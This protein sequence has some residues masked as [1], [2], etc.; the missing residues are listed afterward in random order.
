LCE[1]GRVLSDAL[2][3]YRPAWSVVESCRR[4]LFRT[5]GKSVFFVMADCQNV[6]Y[7]ACQIFVIEFEVD[8]VDFPYCAPPVLGATNRSTRFRTI[9]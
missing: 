1:I 8:L 5:G 3:S 4:F 7:A 9:N 2:E 6:R